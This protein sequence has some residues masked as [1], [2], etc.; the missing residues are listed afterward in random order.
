MRWPTR[1]CGQSPA[2]RPASL[3]E[4]RR[5]VFQPIVFLMHSIDRVGSVFEFE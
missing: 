4:S 5:V 2:I 3:A 1:A